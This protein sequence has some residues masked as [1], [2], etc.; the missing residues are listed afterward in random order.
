M[1]CCKSLSSSKIV[2]LVSEMVKISTRLALSQA[3]RSTMSLEGPSLAEIKVLL[4]SI[5]AQIRFSV[6]LVDR[7]GNFTHAQN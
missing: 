5:S 6:P 7:S 3:C 2:S 4:V 1:Q